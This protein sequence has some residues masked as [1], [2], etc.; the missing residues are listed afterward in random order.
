MNLIEFYEKLT[1]TLRFFPSDVISI[2]PPFKDKKSGLS[3]SHKHPVNW[4]SVK[5]GYF[6]SMSMLQK[7]QVTIIETPQW[8]FTTFRL[9]SKVNV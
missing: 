1:K 9:K 2:D 5:F 8:K 3:D 7:S 6:P 4:K